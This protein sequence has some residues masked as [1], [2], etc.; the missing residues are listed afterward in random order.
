MTP[1]GS[2]PTPGRGRPSGRRS[3]RGGPTAARSAPELIG[4]GVDG[5][6]SGRDAVVLGT[7]LARPTSA[8]VMLI[9]VHEEPLVPVAL[10]GGMSWR[11]LEKRART[12]L[13][14]TRDSLAPDARI[15][16]HADVL[17]WRG[18]RHVVR[19]EHR[20]LLVVGSARD[21]DE[22]CVRLGRS[23]SELL[24]QLEC[25]LAIAPVGFRERETRP[26]RLIGVGYDDTP[27]SQVALALAASIAL[28][29][30][31]QLEVRG[32]IDDHVPGGLRTEQVVPEGKA[33][34]AEQLASAFERDV[35]AAE[36]VGPPARVEIRAGSPTEILAELGDQVDLLVIGS[37][38]SGRP[39]R[40]QLGGTGRGLLGRARCPV[41]LVPRP[42]GP[43]TPPDP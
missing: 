21:A 40:V 33:I 42:A 27:E 16:V 37:A 15:V 19:L 25:P 38:R 24:S 20:D 29:C 4:V 14:Q 39:G 28:A 13:A 11:A 6:P 9:A 22:G 36:A 26:L 43:L 23:A 10:P 17:V 35:A 1:P 3:G 41:V 8:E 18:L 12:M 31:A 32:A 7:L 5:T 2:T 34:I 30:G